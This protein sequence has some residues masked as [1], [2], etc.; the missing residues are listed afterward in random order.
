MPWIFQ[1]QYLPSLS[2]DYVANDTNLG[3]RL[4]KLF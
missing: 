1:G 3:K 2:V 4:L